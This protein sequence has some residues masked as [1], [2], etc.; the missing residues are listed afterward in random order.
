[1]ERVEKDKCRGQPPSKHPDS[2]TWNTG[3]IMNS[4]PL[5]IIPVD[6][7]PYLTPYERALAQHLANTG[8][9]LIE[10]SEKGNKNPA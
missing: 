5:P 3:G 2:R 10:G 1:M 7:L 6:V 4:A 8:R 9:I